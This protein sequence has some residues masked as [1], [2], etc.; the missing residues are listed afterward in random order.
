MDD[1]GGEAGPSATEIVDYARYIGMDPI[2][3]VN[4]L[5]I[6]E[7]ALCASLPEGW[8]EHTDAAG[9]AFYYNAGSGVSSWEHP[10][11]EYYRS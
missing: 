10:L 11:D 5:W 3:D 7:E 4:L 9:N 1:N 8:T 2:G 6:A